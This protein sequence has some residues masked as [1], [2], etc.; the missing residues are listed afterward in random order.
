[1]RIIV[2]GGSG[3]LGRAAVADLRAAGHD[4]WNLDIAPPQGGRRAASPGST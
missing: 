4:V 3:K 1:M 2:T